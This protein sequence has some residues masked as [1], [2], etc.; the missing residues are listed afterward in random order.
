MSL[1]NFKG[2]LIEILF[3]KCVN[4]SSTD[5]V[6]LEIAI[7]NPVR[8][9]TD[10]FSE[11]KSLRIRD[12]YDFDIYIKMISVFSQRV[13]NDRIKLFKLLYRYY[14]E[15]NYNLKNLIKKEQTEY[16]F[17]YADIRNIATYCIRQISKIYSNLEFMNNIMGPTPL[18]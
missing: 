12:S 4:L 6:Y 3:Q 8:P 14:N 5:I 10:I 15:E 16:D 2:T 7:N 11:M 17:I 13:L 9:S 1:M 18:K